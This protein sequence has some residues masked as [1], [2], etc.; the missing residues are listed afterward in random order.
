MA[1]HNFPGYTAFGTGIYPLLPQCYKMNRANFTD[2]VSDN[3]EFFK[4]CTA[5]GELLNV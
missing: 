2:T 5:W 1:K 4:P 3:P